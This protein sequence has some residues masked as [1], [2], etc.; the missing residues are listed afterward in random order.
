MTVT[1]RLLGIRTLPP[2]NRDDAFGSGRYQPNLE[3]IWMPKPLP[4]QLLATA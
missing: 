3:P 4:S 2:S 1:S